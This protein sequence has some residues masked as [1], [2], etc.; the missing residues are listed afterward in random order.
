MLGSERDRGEGGLD[1]GLV[2]GIADP[3]ALVAELALHHRDV[4]EPELLRRAGILGDAVQHV[5]PVAREQRE[6]LLDLS[7]IAAGDRDHDAPVLR[8]ALGGGLQKIAIA[9]VDRRNLVHRHVVGRHEVV[10]RLVLDGR[11]PGD[12]LGDAFVVEAPVVLVIEL[13][14]RAVVAI[15]LA[16]GAVIARVQL[17]LAVEGLDVLLL[18]LDE[19]SAAPLRGL[20]HA[21]EKVQVA[22]VIGGEFGDEFH[23]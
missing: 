21:Q 6:R 14:D 9:R 23:Q 5:D 16:I 22:H 4:A 12:V 2:A 7:E 10:G 20:D 1:A 17:F 3:D 19:I 8:N 15:G 18:H 13:E 11:E